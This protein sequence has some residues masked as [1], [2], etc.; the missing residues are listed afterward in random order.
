MTDFDRVGII[1]C[2]TMGS[3]IAQVCAAAGCQVTV[4]EVDDAAGTAGLE[5]IGAFT[6]GGVSRGKLTEADR[7]AL[8]SRV[9]A[10]TDVAA[11]ADCD[12]VIETVVEDAGV[13]HTV[14]AAAAGVVRPGTVITTNTSAVAVTE[15]A[16]SVRDPA[17]FAGLH[18][19]NPVPV[20][21]L[22]EVVRGLRTAD[23]VVTS[24]IA[25]AERLGKAPVEVKDR[26][27]FLVNRLLIPYLNDVIQAY[28]DG[29]AS[30]DDLDVALELGL[31]YP[32]G[33]LALLDIIGLDT[34]E[35]ASRNAYAGTADPQFAPPPLLRRMVA[36]GKLG[37]KSGEGFRVHAEDGT[38]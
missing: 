16:A 19:F 8:L 29:L 36:A 25:F 28:D 18:F 15:L 30:A 3:G 17:R 31:G 38:R 35:Q 32:T 26:P 1:G 23:D 13:K 14:L 37:R 12:L 10:S 33:P 22:V 7:D 34:H 21:E 6:A 4:L 5:R 11:L 9:S 24:L 20:V 27:G 2:G